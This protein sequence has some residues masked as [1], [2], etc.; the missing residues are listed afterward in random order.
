MTVRCVK[1]IAQITALV[2]VTLNT[3][4]LT[5]ARSQENENAQFGNVDKECYNNFYKKGFVFFNKFN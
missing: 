5:A 2:A 4:S 3:G 1:T